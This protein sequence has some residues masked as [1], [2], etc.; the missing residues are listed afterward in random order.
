MN[1][2]PLFV[3]FPIALLMVYAVMEAGGPILFR[4]LKAVKKEGTELAQF[5]AGELYKN[6]KAFLVI[7]GVAFGYTTLQTGEMAEHA[8]Q[9]SSG[10]PEM[11]AATNAGQLVELHSTFATASIWLFTVLAVAYLF[12]LSWF[13]KYGPLKK[14]S[15]II[16]NP[17][18]ASIL[19]IAGI[20]LLTITGALGGA[21]SHGQDVDPVVKFVYSWFF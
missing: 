18:I 9:S 4:V 14:F 16:L 6:I 20:T 3:H 8:M 17:W 5:V 12:R 13:T 7:V 2:H 1:I 10:D 21:I 11:F 19:A 15:N